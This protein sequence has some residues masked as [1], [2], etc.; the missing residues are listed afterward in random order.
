MEAASDGL[1]QGRLKGMRFA[2]AGFTN[3]TQDHLNT[4]G[5]MEAYFEAKASLFDGS[6]TEHAVINVGDAYGKVLRERITY[7]VLTFGTEHS[8]LVFE[9]RADASG[10]DG[11]VGTLE[12]RSPLVGDYNVA[13]CLCAIG[14]ALQCGIEKD[15]ISQGI[16][17]MTEVPGR[18]ER[19]DAGQQYLAL[20]DYAHTPDA[21]ANV[22]RASKDLAGEHRLIVVFGCGGD[23]DRAKRPL[24]GEAA[25]KVA[26]L[27]IVTSD[28]PRTEDP[29]A[30]VRE[31]EPGAKRGGG[32]YELIVDRETAIK[33]AVRRAAPGDVVLVAGKG[34]EQGQQFADRTIPFDDR[35]VLRRAIEEVA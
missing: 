32:A 20:V 21:L 18:L 30:I 19:V 13:N 29:E 24:M 35:D 17:S 25:T 16:A 14:I 4:H 22:V 11:R 2:S 33:E 3:L 31:I 7:D 26:D 1:A 34:H 10:I 27:T 6:Y 8:D 23:R 15:A 12:L 28:N 9:G 5:S